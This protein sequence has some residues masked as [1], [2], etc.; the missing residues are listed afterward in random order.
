MLIGNHAIEPPEN[1]QSLYRQRIN[2]LL[3]EAISYPLVT[4]IAGPGFGKTESVAA[5][6]RKLQQQGAARIA[7]FA[8]RK[9]DNDLEQLRTKLVRLLSASFPESVSREQPPAGADP[10]AAILAVAEEI[11]QA[12]PSEKKQLFIIDRVELVSNES[13]PTLFRELAS[14]L[15]ASNVCWV[16]LSRV[17][18][19][20]ELARQGSRE[21]AE[22]T[23]AQLAFSRDE[24]RDFW[25]K[26]GLAIAPAELDM[27]MEETEGWPLAVQV[28][29]QLAQAGQPY[30][31]RDSYA[32]VRETFQEN[33]FKEYSAELKALML[34][35]AMLPGFSLAVLKSLARGLKIPYRQARQVVEEHPFI[36]Y[37]YVSHSF[38]LH[39]A[40]RQFLLHKESLLSQQ[41]RLRLLR[42]VGEALASGGQLVEAIVCFEKIGDY[43]RILKT[44]RQ[45]ALH[46]LDVKTCEQITQI[47]CSFS[48]DFS[49]KHPLVEL[50][51]AYID[52][53]QIKIDAAD[54]RLRSLEL[55]LKTRT[56]KNS[57]A[58][59]GEVYLLLATTRI[60]KNQDDFADY[61]KKAAAAFPN[62]APLH[63]D[64]KHL[65]IINSKI[66]L[67]NSDDPREMERLKQL[68]TSC[69]PYLEH[70]KKGAG[71]SFYGYYA[72]EAAFCT[73]DLATAEQLASKYTYI[74]RENGLCFYVLHGLWIQFQIAYMSGNLQLAMKIKEHL[75]EYAES[76]TAFV[77]VFLRD[78]IEIYIDIL[79][80][81]LERIPK[82]FISSKNVEKSRLPILIDKEGITYG[83]YLLKAKDYV[84]L[85]YYLDWFEKTYKNSGTWLSML[86]SKLLRAIAYMKL[87]DEKRALE[88]LW[89]AYRLTEK[90]KIITPFIAFGK[91]MR[92]LTKL[93]Q[94][95]ETYHFEPKWLA[96]IHQKSS[97]FAKKMAT[98][99][100]EHLGQPASQAP[101]ARLSR[102]EFD[103]LTALSQGLTREEIASM[104]NV[105]SGT[106][107]AIIKQLYNKLDA[108]NNAAAVRIAYE[109]GI[110]KLDADKH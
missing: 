74:A 81:D 67:T 88:E 102:R 92:T 28:L 62:D 108:V 25:A 98:M 44:A 96:T 53:F 34:Q 15:K 58:Q 14:R 10:I 5:F 48:A 9:E 72:M 52:L 59:L 6:S 69:I 51:L 55:R 82:W 80:G 17:K 21:L 93:A 30:G 41:E 56:D 7:G 61:Y 49:Q 46:Q 38:C 1:D 11:R 101:Q 31:M 110:F 85:V 107:K 35:L 2:S 77:C 76:S 16:I 8:M 54:A 36:R 43:A 66:Y 60:M 109:T 19:R 84:E 40:Y 4:I 79:F 33:C 75:L 29:N 20:L 97:T 64:M 104:T 68:I 3:E 12:P 99:E 37:N 95:S 57:L 94:S 24:V 23:Q 39:N 87:K 13:I 22:I 89:A 18:S 26:T 90:S 78:Q 73:Y 63:D 27:V 106:V 32:R 45:L 50:L 65:L 86:R 47:L 91:D 71:H 83:Y 70:F 100:K 103:V 105:S 42:I